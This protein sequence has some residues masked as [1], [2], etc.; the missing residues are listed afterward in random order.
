MT[1]VQHLPVRALLFIE[2]QYDKP[3]SYILSTIHHHIEG[4]CEDNWLHYLE[5][6]VLTNI[7]E[8][9]IACNPNLYVD[10]KSVFEEKGFVC[11]YR[12]I[13]QEF[14]MQCKKS[15]C[16]YNYVMNWVNVTFRQNIIIEH[17]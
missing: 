17:E 8:L 10:L 15:C 13:I 14:C 5:R 4:K 3:V 2:S 16:K 11:K 9:V 6:K 12:L 7:S 1:L